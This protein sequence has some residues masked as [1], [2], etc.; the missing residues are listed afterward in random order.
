MPIIT[1]PNKH[2]DVLTWSGTGGSASATRSLTGLNFQPD[3]VWEKDRASSQSHHLFDS[4]SVDS[5]DS[6]SVVSVNSVKFNV[7][8]FI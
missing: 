2:F 7:I 4:I 1:N 8:L 6:I 5:L 3:F